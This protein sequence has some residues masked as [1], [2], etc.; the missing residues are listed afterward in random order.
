MNQPGSVRLFVVEPA[1]FDKVSK[2]CVTALPRVARLAS[3]PTH[4]LAATGDTVATGTR[5]LNS[6]VAPRTANNGRAAT[7]DRT[8][9]T[10]TLPSADHA[11]PSAPGSR[12][13]R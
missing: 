8:V 3:P 10:A 6:T 11:N 2:F 12:A 9:G 5:P 4:V 13:R 1:V 7:L